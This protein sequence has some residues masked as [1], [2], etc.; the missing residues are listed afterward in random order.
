MLI[1]SHC[2]VDFPELAENLPVVLEQMRQN[3][4]GGAICI[5]VTLEEFPRI[6]ALIEADPR[7]VATVGLHPETTEGRE[8]TLDELIELAQAPEVVAIGETGLDY[9]WHKDKPE[10]QRDRFRTHIRA[11][12]AIGKPLVIHNRDATQDV[13]RLMVEERA[14][15][16]GGVMHCFT[17][18]WD[19][20][21]AV[22]DLGFHISIS[23]IVTFKNATQM[24]AVAQR[25]PLDRLLV[26]TDA[27]YLSPVPYR[28]KLN[29][30]GYVKYVA[31]EIARLRG[32]PFEAL[33]R[34]TTENCFRLFP[35][36]KARMTS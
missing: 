33:A 32:V 25:V 9:Y 16:V 7:I 31:E 24:K 36:A 27:P 11:A 28:G 3:G 15:D 4:V 10:W 12:R 22:L 21:Q 34:A 8:A 19:I 35:F 26:E 20:A 30:P 5:G 6:R 14:G 2:H 23:G 13:L 18:S 1:D 29:Q 17:E